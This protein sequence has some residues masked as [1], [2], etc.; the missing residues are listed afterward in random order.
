MKI[1]ICGYGRAALE[2]V[3]QLLLH[4]EIE[5]K[6]LLVFTHNEKN[7]ECLTNYLD[8]QRVDYCFES[9][10]N[11][12]EHVK[13][14]EPSLLISIYYKFI[15]KKYILE[16]CL[17]KAMNLHPSLLPAYR[18]TKSSVWAI[19]N[20]E[21]YTGITFHY[22]NEKID[23]GNIILQKK[24]KIQGNDTAYSLYHKLIS[25][26]IFHFQDA[27]EKL[28]SGFSGSKQEGRVTFY[29][30]KL[31]HNGFL[32]CNKVTYG[33]AQLFVRAMYFPPHK[34]ARFEDVDGNI[35]EVSSIKELT[36]Y[37]KLFK[38]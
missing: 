10:N 11:C 18:G 29:K 9:I 15:I 13:D 7:N 1:I 20:K 27:F 31:P 33:Y 6:E 36:K 4:N 21:I 19:L 34:P 38:E 16:I 12:K 17:F 8:V 24:I 22:I 35:F 25:C 5:P 2:C 37:K 3:N 23:D 26:F 30:R 32:R 28:V 14:F